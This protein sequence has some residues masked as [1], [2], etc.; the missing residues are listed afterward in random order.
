MG[1][2]AVRGELGAVD[3]LRQLLSAVQLERLDA[4]SETHDTAH[5]FRFCGHAS[6]HFSPATG[7][8]RINN[9][10]ALLP[11]FPASLTTASRAART[12]FA[13][14]AINELESYGIDINE[15]LSPADLRRGRAIIKLLMAFPEHWSVLVPSSN[16]RDDDLIGV[17]MSHAFEVDVII[18]VCIDRPE[19]LNADYLTGYLDRTAPSLRD[20]FL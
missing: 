9:L 19:L 14:K 18:D 6:E 16:D 15:P 10:T 8:Q 20:G 5:V 13:I 7:A 17:L 11:D 3:P 1:D 12:Q 2:Y 4:V